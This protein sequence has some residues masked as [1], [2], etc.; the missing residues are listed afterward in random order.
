MSQDLFTARLACE[1]HCLQ[2]CTACKEGTF[3]RPQ[4]ACRDGV[5]MQFF[6]FTQCAASAAIM[7]GQ[8]PA[9]TLS[10]CMDWV[11]W[12]Q[13]PTPSPPSIE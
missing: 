1:H 9:V 4:M 12:H 8:P 6:W 3:Q 11:A 7:K 13:P 10:L 5:V 2:P